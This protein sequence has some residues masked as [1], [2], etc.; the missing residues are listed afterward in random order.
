MAYPPTPP[1]TRT[2]SDLLAG[3]HAADHTAI[4]NALT[5]IINE[6]GTNP[7]GDSASLTAFL[8]LLNPVGEIKMYGGSS[9]PS[10]WALCDGTAVSRTTY[11]DLFAVIGTAF[12]AGDGTTTFNLPDF[13]DRYAIGDSASLTL[14]TVVGSN[15][16]VAVAHTHGHPDHSHGN[17]F[18]ASTS[19]SDGSHAHTE[20]YPGSGSTGWLYSGAY[21]GVNYDV[22]VGSG[23]SGARSTYAYTQ[24]STGT[25]G[26]THGHTV[27]LS[28]GVSDGNAGTTNSQSPTA[29]A[30]G[31]NRPASVPVNFIIR[32]T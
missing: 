19:G 8:T 31:A 29:S 15:D 21:D 12:G 30:T 28:G 1:S 22:Y 4:A 11:A 18:S 32:L 6:L 3:N 9:A 5:D 10:G 14:G 13:R 27:T 2:G 20:S 16:A 25:G 7:K 26:S 24:P 17:T 23:L